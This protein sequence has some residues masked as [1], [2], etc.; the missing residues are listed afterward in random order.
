ML[1]LVL[2]PALESVYEFVYGLVIESEF[3]PELDLVRTG[4]V[5]NEFGLVSWIVESEVDLAFAFEFVLGNVSEDGNGNGVTTTM[6][7]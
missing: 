4:V 3:E 1:V 6:Q 5:K 7:G 2:E